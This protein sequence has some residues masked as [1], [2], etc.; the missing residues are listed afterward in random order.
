MFMEKD[1]PRLKV[2]PVSYFHTG[3]IMTPGIIHGIMG[4]FARQYSRA[5]PVDDY[6]V[7]TLLHC[8]P[9][10]ITNHTN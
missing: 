1:T 7:S 6:L 4:T 9:G 5:R 10:I 8:N 3:A 2:S